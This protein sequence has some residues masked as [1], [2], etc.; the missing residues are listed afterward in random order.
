MTTHIALLRAV[1]VGGTKSVS[2]SSLRDV[3]AALGF[4]EVQSLVQS[5]N[6]V[7]QSSGRTPDDLESLLEAEVYRRLG[8]RTEFF[9]RTARQWQ[10]IVAGN[11]FEDEAD[12]DPSHLVLMLLKS[13]A[14]STRVDALRAAITGPERVHGG[15]RHA[16]LTYP[17][18]IGRS[19]VTS[20]LIERRLETP[21]T[22]RNWNT[23]LKLAALATAEPGNRRTK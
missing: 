7:F 9:V 6:L 12:R 16:Y 11:P 21:G 10:A 3:L 17:E 23:V 19:R 2:M 20:A 14:T 13:R 15:G 8:V 18:G 5:G 22:A 4:G 1:N